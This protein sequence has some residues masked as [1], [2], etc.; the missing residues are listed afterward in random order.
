MFKKVLNKFVV[1]S[2][3]AFTSGFQIGCGQ[4]QDQDETDNVTISGTLAGSQG[5]QKLMSKNSASSVSN[6]EVYCVTFSDNPASAKSAISAQ[7]DFSLAMPKGVPFGCFINDKASNRPIATIA[8]AGDDESFGG[9]S[10]TSIELKQSVE[11]GSLQLD[12]E[13]G[14]VLIARDTIAP[15]LSPIRESGL[16]LDQVHNS[17]YTMQCLTTGNAYVDQKCQDDIADSN[18]QNS[19]YL[20]IMRAQRAGEDIQGIGVWESQQAFNDCGSIDLLDSTVADLGANDGIQ[21]LPS[22]VVS[23]PNFSTGASC[24]VRNSGAVNDH[25]NLDKYYAAGEL[26]RNG[27][28]YTLYAH[29]SHLA[30]AGCRIEHTTVVHFT[31]E[32]S[33]RMVG[34]FMTRE[35]NVDLNNGLGDCSH[36]QDTPGVSFSVEFTKQ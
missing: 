15:A 4:T 22:G 24:P 1:I 11:L 18:G 7:G 17:T 20:R 30:N 34:Q 33:D 3:L 5:Q 36:L 28:G 29:D 8:I 25:E 26:V 2:C 31:G 23:G 9:A 32:S 16:D 10:S 27:N 35:M 6:Y 19:V 21:F 13:R 12:L 14:E